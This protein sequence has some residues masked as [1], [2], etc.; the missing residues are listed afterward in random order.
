MRTSEKDI[1]DRKFFELVP[2]N[3]AVIDRDYN[4]V[5]ANERFKKFFGA[6][7]KSK[8]FEVC[9][10]IKEPCSH[11]KVEEVFASGEERVLNE[12]GVNSDGISCHYIVHFVPVKD[13][14]GKVIYVMELSSELTEAGMYQKEADVL[15]DSVPCYI[16]VIDKN[17]KIVK[18]NKKFRD[19]FG[20]SDKKFCY[21]VYKKRNSPC[22]K[23]PARLSF[24]DGKEHSSHQ[25]GTTFSGDQTQYLVNTT[26]ISRDHGSVSL[27]M[28]IATDITEISGLQEQL[29]QAHDFHTTL[30]NNSSNGIIALDGQG[31]V[32]IFNPTAGKMLNWTSKRKPGLKKIKDMLPASF[33][34]CSNT[35]QDYSTGTELKI[36]SADNIEIPVIFDGVVL[37]SKKQCIGKVAF[38]KD[39]R[40]I[41]QLEKEKLDAE[42]LGA[43]GQTVAGLA[44][45]IKNILMGLEGGMYMVD[46]GL[47]TANTKRIFEGWDVLQRNFTKTTQLVKDFLS[48]SKGKLPNLKV[49]NPNSLVDDIIEL[50][51]DTAANR[52]VQLIAETD[53][54]MPEVP[55]D[56]DGMEACLTNLVSNAIDAVLLRPDDKGKVILKTSH[57]K[58]NIYIEVIDNGIGMEN[59]IHEKIFTTFFTTKGGKGTGLGLLTTRK[60]VQEHGGY[61]D[62]DTQKGKGSTFTIRLLKDRLNMIYD[63]TAINK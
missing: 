62:V 57:D 23:C 28:E 27:I 3:V 6:R 1:I 46:S 2:F 13:D 8:C 17:Y 4:I 26:P 14:D 56:P 11:C 31:K 44:H 32:K 49:I 29:Q 15:F 35:D 18:A 21:E 39:L 51:R 53:E 33:F 40:P 16:T 38:I 63:K 43:V 60:I 41:K 48:F 58:D 25:I 59:D 54:N 47:K 36:Q 12:T 55:L 19:T 5:R 10:K 45:T 20:D 52:G 24:E 34:E 9:K 42:R 50:Y 7:E 61:I 22:Q 30:I 37:K